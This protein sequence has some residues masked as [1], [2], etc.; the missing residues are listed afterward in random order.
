[1]HDSK[2]GKQVQN[3][4]VNSRFVKYTLPALDSSSTLSGLRCLIILIIR[5]RGA[6]EL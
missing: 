4:L 5:L 2:R 3:V 1:M 6:I